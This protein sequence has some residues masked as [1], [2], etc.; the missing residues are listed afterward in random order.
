MTK[1]SATITDA[2]TQ[3]HEIR[4]TAKPEAGEVEAAAPFDTTPARLFQALTSRDICAWWVRPDAFDTRDWSGD[5]RVGGRWK[6][7]GVGGGRPY[8]LEGGFVEIDEPRALVRTWKPAGAPGDVALPTYD[9][10]PEDE[11]VRVTLR[12][13]GLPNPEVM[14]KTSVGWEASLARLRE[15][16]SAEKE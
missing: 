3:N 7:A 4:A 1:R 8:E 9:L 6:A 5:V 12:H 14:E 10:K 2:T 15:P 16:L 13:C 11:G